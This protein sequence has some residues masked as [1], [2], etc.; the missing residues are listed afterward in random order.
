MSEQLTIKALPALPARQKGSVLY[1]AVIDAAQLIEICSGL[2][3]STAQEATNGVRSFDT[4]EDSQRLAEAL[5]EPAFAKEVVFAQEDAYD[6]D[7]PYQRIFD[8]ARVK[9]IASYLRE[10]DAMLPNAI[11]LATRDD[12]EVTMQPDGD[13]VRL[14]LKWEE[15]A[16]PLN[17]IDGQHRVEGLRLLVND[18]PK[19]YAKFGVPV[20]LLI[21]LPFW[22]QA[23][24]FAVVNGRQKQVSRSRVYDLLGYLPM[25]DK[26]ARNRAYQGEMALHRFCH[27]AIKVLNQSEK[28]P[29]KSRIKMR[30]SGSGVVTQAA[31]VDHLTIYLKPKKDRADTKVFPVLYS[32]YRNSDVVGLAKLLIVYFVGLERA[33]PNFWKTDEA[34]KSSLFGK[35]NGVAVMLQVLHNLILVAG[36]ANK[37]QLAFVIDN[38]K[39]VEPALLAKP[40]SG[41][42]KGYQAILTADVMKQM[43]GADYQQKLASSAEDIRPSLREI[44]A[45]L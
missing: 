44:D 19:E 7:Q 20:T 15:G 11:I 45:L 14:E 34:L 43:L 6:D 4:V 39:K 5:N 32:Y 41:G 35:T 17:I 24:L 28:S 21:D 1:V 33:H 30:G 27:Y 26:D 8:E 9:N 12:V 16:K 37:L 42:S 18:S 38:W 23:Q 36:G 40:P 13:L 31:L 29:W 3:A 25:T 10:E 2:R 22:I